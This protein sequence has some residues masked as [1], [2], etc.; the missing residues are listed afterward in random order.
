MAGAIVDFSCV[1]VT[2]TW[3]RRRYIR[4]Q[5]TPI[6]RHLLR[7]LVWKDRHCETTWWA[8]LLTAL[9]SGSLSLKIML[10][11]ALNMR[12]NERNSQLA[13]YISLL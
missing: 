8:E 9:G 6:L 7:A 5:G 13:G 3:I 2:A 1:R 12:R 10:K 4:S 11:P